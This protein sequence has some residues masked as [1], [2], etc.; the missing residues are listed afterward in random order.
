[1]FKK[2]QWNG[3]PALEADNQYCKGLISLHGA[4]VLSYVPNG[5]KDLLWRSESSWHEDGK[6]IRGGIPVCWPWF[7]PVPEP[8]HGL[9]RLSLWNIKEQNQNSDGEDRIVLSFSLNGIQAELS[10]TFGKELTVTLKTINQSPKELVLTEALH[11][12]FHISDIAQ[13]QVEGLE[14]I[15]YEDRLTSVQAIQKDA[16]RFDCETDRT[17]FTEGE[18]VVKDSGFHRSIRIRKRGS[19]TTVVWNPWIAKS[20]RMPD[21]GNEEYHTMV[22]VE[23]ANAG[24]DAITLQPGQEHEI[25]TILSLGNC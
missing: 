6:P 21:F 8:A 22:C 24:K 19:K 4:H 3:L 11:S 13:I 12:Y 18:A 2:T 5:E 17:Y 20:A 14:G 16:I 15:A 25:T 7:G 1:M 9:A 10:A 23:A